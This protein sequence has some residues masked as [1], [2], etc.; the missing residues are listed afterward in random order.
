[1][2][3]SQVIYLVLELYWKLFDANE[4]YIEKMFINN[5]LL[6]LMQSI[7]LCEGQGALILKLKSVFQPLKNGWKS[8]R[9]DKVTFIPYQT[10][11]FSYMLI[12]LASC[13]LVNEQIR[14]LVIGS[15]SICAQEDEGC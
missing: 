6:G 10:M 14:V 4:I 3:S 7:L 9:F 15:A 11:H 13:N 8:S 12:V 1:M 2:L 5:V